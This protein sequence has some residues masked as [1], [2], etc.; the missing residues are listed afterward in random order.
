MACDVML[1]FGKL[2][3]CFWLITLPL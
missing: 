2:K 1:I 3:F